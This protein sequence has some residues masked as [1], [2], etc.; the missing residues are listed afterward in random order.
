M[1]KAYSVTRLCNALGVARSTYYDWLARQ[2]RPANKQH[3]LLLDEVEKIHDE[4][5]ESYGRRRM[6]QELRQRAFNVGP[7]QARSLMRT[8][9]LVVRMPKPPIYPKNKG[10]PD[11]ISPTHLNRAFDGTTPGTTVAGDMTY[12]WTR[13]GWFYLAIV[14]DLCARRIVGWALSGTPDTTL[15]KRALTLALPHRHKAHQLLFHSDQGCQYTSTAFRQYL[16]NN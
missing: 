7:Y 3:R 13:N 4:V 10:K 8:A 1:K 14:M 2:K 9:G 6:S 15:A 11:V 16:D 5:G 12:I